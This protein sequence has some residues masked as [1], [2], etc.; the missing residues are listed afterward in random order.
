MEIGLTFGESSVLP[1][2]QSEMTN[3]H[4]G[5]NTKYLDR[6]LSEEKRLDLS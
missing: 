3:T 2:T 4:S 6:F 5:E 1:E